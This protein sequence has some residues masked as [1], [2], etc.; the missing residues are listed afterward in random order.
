MKHYLTL[1]F[2]SMFIITIASGQSVIT[3]PYNPDADGD[4]YVATTDMLETLAVF[5]QDFEPSEIIISDTPL[6]EFLLNLQGQVDLLSDQSI[7]IANLESMVS[8]LST[9]LELQ[10]QF[11][12]DLTAQVVNAENMANMADMNAMMAYDMA[13]NADMVAMDAYMMAEMASMDAMMASSDAMMAS[14]DAMMAMDVASMADMNAMDAQMFASNAEST[15]MMASSDAMMAMDMASM[16]ESTAMNA[17]GTAMDAQMMASNADMNA[18]MA[19]DMA[20][21][22]A[23]SI[24][25]IL[26]LLSLAGIE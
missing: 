18:M 14:S 10:D 17:E 15:A 8:S 19:S 4:S 23:A 21:L 13:S 20:I 2:I 3:Y 16:A 26:S 12:V 6:E 25:D 9:A 24:T 7:T 1:S 22:N 5:G 11:I